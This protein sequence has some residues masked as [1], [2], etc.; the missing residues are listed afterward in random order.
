MYGVYGV[1]IHLGKLGGAGGTFYLFMMWIWIWIRL[2]ILSFI[3]LMYVSF[4]R[5]HVFNFHFLLV[6]W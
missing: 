6:G 5:M 2:E 3:R 1:C 4:S